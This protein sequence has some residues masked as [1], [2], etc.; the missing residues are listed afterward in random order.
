MT[1]R[2]PS[3]RTRQ[4]N[5]RHQSPN[6]SCAAST[7]S[8]TKLTP[9]LR[10]VSSLSPTLAVLAVLA[11]A[12]TST[13]PPPPVA[14]A[15]LANVTTT[16]SAPAGQC[17]AGGSRL[18]ISPDG[19]AGSVVLTVALDYVTGPACHFDSAVE[20]ALGDSDGHLLP[21]AGNPISA[22]M[23][24]DVG[25]HQREDSSHSLVFSWDNW[26]GAVAQYQAVAT[27]GAFSS[28][29]LFSRPRPACLNAANKSVLRPF[30]E[31]SH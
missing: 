29:L 25:P 1:S 26:C 19:A 7:A 27:A 14:R 9:M 23:S 13:A 3:V 28:Q 4:L 8:E 12:C 17:Q 30:S 21:I 16:P 11:C 5:A 18:V 6:V 31:A 22:H 20:L 2:R 15:P 24:A 10:A